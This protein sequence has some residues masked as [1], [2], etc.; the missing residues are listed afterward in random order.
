MKRYLNI[1]MLLVL[2]L[3]GGVFLMSSCLKNN[4]Y[5][6]DFGDYNPS[7]EFPMAAKYVNKPFG[8]DWSPDTTTSFKIYINVASMDK[9]NLPVT[10]TIDIDK[11]WIDQYNTEQ[12]ASAKQAQEDYLADTSHRTSDPAYPYSW[13]PMEILPDSLYEISIGGSAA[14]VPFQLSVP[15]KE[16]QAYADVLIH[17]DKFPAG[18]NYVLPF[19]MT[20]ASTTISSWNH[21]GLWFI[22]SPFT[23]TFTNYSVV[24]GVYSPTRTG[25]TVTLATVDQH[26]VE[27]GGFLDYYSGSTTYHFL[28]DGS[29]EVTANS[30]G[31]LGAETIESHSDPATGNFYVKYK[32]NGLG[33][34]V[35]EETYKR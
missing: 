6:V 23:G 1:K 29:V 5:Y 33:G 22:T 31:D 18:H 11:A 28:G 27:A 17:T 12:A 10:A 25:Q 8:I 9:P 20:D 34:A 14:Q 32:C 19:T 4:K 24:D 21:L 16:R 3:T 15:A 30:G 2:A 26:T 7:V 13:T 35:F